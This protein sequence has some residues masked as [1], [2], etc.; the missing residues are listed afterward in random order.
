M[1]AL[2]VAIL[3]AAAAPPAGG[4]VLV[5]GAAAHD[6]HVSRL[7]VNHDTGRERVELTL[8]TFV[9]DLERALVE[10]YRLGSAAAGTLPSA[11]GINLLGP[12]QHPSADS[13]VEGYLRGQLAL[14][15][16]GDRTLDWR[17]VG[18]E[19]ATDPYAMYVYL[20]LDGPTAAS[21][22]KLRSGFLVEVFPDQQ[23]VVIWQRDGESRDFDLLTARERTCHWS[24]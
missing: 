10:S 6:F 15:D 12:R 16:E 2:L 1:I 8:Q 7:T 24:K 19:R 13:L 11:A 5:A 14:L 17:F 9:D 23:N 4:D 20:V 22:T 18:M 3:I 21:A